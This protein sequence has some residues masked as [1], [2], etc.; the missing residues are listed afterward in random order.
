MDDQQASFDL[1]FKCEDFTVDIPDNDPFDPAGTDLPGLI[2]PTL[3]PATGNYREMPTVGPTTA[4]G[5]WQIS[6]LSIPLQGS[7][8]WVKI[9]IQDAKTFTGIDRVSFDLTGYIN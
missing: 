3:L 6:N 7:K 4:K 5:Q 2:G 1:Y 8:C 9:V